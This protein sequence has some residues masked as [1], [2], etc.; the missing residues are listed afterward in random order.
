MKRFLTVLFLAAAFAA[1]GVAENR[2]SVTAE[3][4][5]SVS[6]GNDL[7][8]WTVSPLGSAELSVRNTGSRQV[9]S[10]LLLRFSNAGPNLISELDRLYIRATLGDLLATV[11]KTRSSWGAGIA[12]NAGDL[13]FGSSSVDFSLRAAD[14]RSETA[15]LL[16]AELPID[17]FSFV[18]LVLL[19]GELDLSN[20]FAPVLPGVEE[21]SVG[22]RVNLALGDLTL[23]TGYLFRGD[24]IAG[25]GETGHHAHVMLEGYVPV[26]WHFTTATRTS[27]DRWDADAIE[28]S[29]T[30]TSGASGDIS[31]GMDQRIGWQL[32]ALI[33]PFRS[34][35]PPAGSPATEYGIF[36]YPGFS[37]SS[38]TGMTLLANA[39]VSPADLS[40]RTTLG[41]NW[42]IYQ[43]LTLLSYLSVAA[44]EP[45]DLFAV[46]DP[47]GVSLLV[48]MRYVY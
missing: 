39:I 11:G 17:D 14:P 18:E 22:T 28:D 26:T 31:F 12:F 34:F 1:G 38:G 13:I 41:M 16:S 40:A 6:S 2:V 10:E 25:R 23:E 46:A 45:G 24:R 48:G 33:R 9:R 37:L 4:L 3:L 8:L 36:V 29:V 5:N 30:V 19:P 27:R 21:A 44:G 32:E 7:E 20:P 42:N 47:G 43:S 35:D 15:W